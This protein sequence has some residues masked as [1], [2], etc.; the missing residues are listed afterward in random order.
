MKSKTSCL[1]GF[2]HITCFYFTVSLALFRQHIGITT[3]LSVHLS[4]LDNVFDGLL[5]QVAHVFH[6]NTLV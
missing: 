2:L 5:Q 1:I 4:D 6:W 3:L